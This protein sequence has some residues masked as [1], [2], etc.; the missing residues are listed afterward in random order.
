MYVIRQTLSKLTISITCAFVVKK[1]NADH[2]SIEIYK[3]KAVYVF[4]SCD[5]NIF[6]NVR[7][8]PNHINLKTCAIPSIQST[9]SKD[10]SS[11]K[12]TCIISTPLNP[13]FIYW[14]LQGYTFF[15]LFL[16]KNIDCGYSLEPPQWGSSNEYPQS[17]FWAE[18]WK[19]SEIV[20]EY[21]QFLVV[22]FSVYLNRHVF[23]MNQQKLLFIHHELEFYIS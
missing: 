5:W 9:L 18:I 15:S 22:K 14:G 17:M 11:Q 20:S 16:L 3:N 10:H 2:L 7:T 1:L 13:T 6:E 21:I 4:V 12:H 8:S 23:V 19:I